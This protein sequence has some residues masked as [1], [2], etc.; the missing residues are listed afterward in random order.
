M[1]RGHTKH[2]ITHALHEDFHSQRDLPLEVERLGAGVKAFPC[3]QVSTLQHCGG[4]QTGRPA[5]TLLTSGI[6]E[7]ADSKLSSS[8][9]Q[10]FATA[11]IHSSASRWCMLEYPGY[12][13][14]PACR[15]TA[16]D[17]ANFSSMNC[18]WTHW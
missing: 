8:T 10:D 1:Y 6:W 5:V 18:T 3:E 4:I 7:L 11:E 17:L 14:V 12:V 13:H 2:V 9:L 15:V 16:C